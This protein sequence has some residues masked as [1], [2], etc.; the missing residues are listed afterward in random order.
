[1]VFLDGAA[2]SKKSDEKD[3]TSN[4]DYGLFHTGQE[5]PEWIRGLVEGLLEELMG[6]LG[7]RR[8]FAG[9]DALALGALR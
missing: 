9:D 1:M 7:W 6:E 5:G 8:G 3:D 2:A 4:H